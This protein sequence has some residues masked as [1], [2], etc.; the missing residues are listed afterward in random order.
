M[1]NN[2]LFF[3]WQD[4][5]QHMQLW[6]TDGTDT[7]S[8]HVITLRQIMPISTYKSSYIFLG[9]DSNLIQSLWITDGTSSGTRIIKRGNKYWNANP[10][11]ACSYKDKIF[12]LMNDSTYIA[13]MWYTDG[14][15]TGTHI[16]YKDNL[17]ILSS[18]NQYIN[19]IDSQ[20][21]YSASDTAHGMELWT[22]DGTDSGTHMLVEINPGPKNQGAFTYSTLKFNGKL[23]FGGMYGNA[24]GLYCSDGTAKGTRIIKPMNSVFYGSIL[25][26]FNNKFYFLA[27]DSRRWA[28][29]YVSD[30]TTAGTKIF[31]DSAGKEIRGTPIA[32]NNKLYIQSYFDTAAVGLYQSDGTSANT[33]VIHA[34]FP[35]SVNYSTFGYYYTIYKNAL[36]LEG[37]YDSTG[38]ELWHLGDVDTPISI[39]S[40]K[41]STILWSIYPNPNNGNFTINTSNPSFDGI[42]SVYDITGR[43]VI[44]KAIHGATHTLQLPAGAKGIYIV[45]LQSGDAVSTKK[46]LVE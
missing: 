11:S 28:C 14:T 39:N 30:G 29:M 1:L 20:I 17:D 38:L 27:E 41:H 36:W 34:A 21:L 46:I 25:E 4:S 22:C 31:T 24:T 3:V 5:Q 19:V 15:D 43:V 7:G 40:I 23:Y 37:Q 8:H 32:Y 42:V 16:I 12:W 26:T 33:Y 9:K 13:Q 44:S 45:K 10:T 18:V 6:T 35:R 2:K